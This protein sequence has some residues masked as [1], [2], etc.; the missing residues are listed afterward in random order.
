MFQLLGLL[1]VIGIA[2]LW[3]QTGRDPLWWSIH[4]L[5]WLRAGIKLAYLEILEGW[6]RYKLAL[7]GAVRE[8]RTELAEEG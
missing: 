1:I 3:L 7:P 8:M 6:R 5:I 4:L 2:G